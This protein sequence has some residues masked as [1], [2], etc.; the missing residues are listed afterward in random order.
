[1]CGVDYETFHQRTPH[2][3]PGATSEELPAL[4]GPIYFNEFVIPDQS[5]TETS[6]D[7]GIVW[8]E[9]PAGPHGKADPR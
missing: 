4:A 9:V 1:M 7:G 5:K 3:V 2:G 8:T 6:E